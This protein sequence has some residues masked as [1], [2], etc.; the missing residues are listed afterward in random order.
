MHVW[1]TT[2]GLRIA[3][4]SWGDPGGP[5]VLLMHGGGQSR[6][7]WRTTGRNLGEAGYHA[8]AVDLRGHGDSEWSPEG[9]YSQDAYVRDIEA[10][11]H[12]L[13]GRTAVLVGASLGAGNGL[14]AVGEDRVDAAA[15]V[16]VDFVPRTERAG[17]ERLQAFMRAHGDGFASL[18]EVSDAITA[19]RGGGQRPAALDGLAKVVRRGNDGRYRWHWDPRQLDWRV[20]EYPTRHVRLSAS[21]HRLGIPTLLVRGGS[22]DVVSEEGAREFLDLCPHA[23]YINLAGAGH[24][25]VGDRN[26]TFGQALIPFLVRE[27]PVLR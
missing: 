6:H 26:D 8:V 15:L 5:L 11:I 18:E 24:M 21:A 17:F 2:E 23:E 12:A 4:D 10:V 20:R 13:G 7:A 25:L 3:A 16:L 22:S 27:V 14:V 9:D 1:P 19:F